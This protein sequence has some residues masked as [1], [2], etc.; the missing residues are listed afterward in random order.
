[1]IPELS[2]SSI[3]TASSC[4][5]RLY[6]QQWQ[7]R[8]ESLRY[9]I[10]KQIA[11]H[12]DKDS[13]PGEV[14]DEVCHVQSIP[15]Q[16]M[17]D[18]FLDCFRICR[19]N[20]EWRSPREIDVAVHSATHHIHGIVDKLFDEDPIFS[21][22]RSAKAPAAGVYQSDR[23][24]IA[25][26]TVCIQE[27]LGRPVSGGSVEYIPS[28]ISR[29]C[30]V[31]PIDKRRFLHALHEARRIRNGALPRR[32]LHPPCEHCPENSRCIPGGG[33]RLSDIL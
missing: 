6:Y 33:M 30:K 3:V 22:V 19:N 32:P 27:M 21:V 1:V 5:L 13:D 23:I 11:Y 16:T 12:L 28:G 24:R 14:W 15:D 31:A 9:T 10:A 8:P 2:I 26:Y 18:F 25:A 29:F 4:P 17:R 20:P 7:E